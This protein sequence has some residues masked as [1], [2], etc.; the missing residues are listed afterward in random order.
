MMSVS[1]RPVAGWAGRGSHAPCATLVCMISDCFS[2]G[3]F[4]SKS[5]AQLERIPVEVQSIL[6][7]D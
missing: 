5:E 4:H 2:L 6:V 3:S 7:T 1:A